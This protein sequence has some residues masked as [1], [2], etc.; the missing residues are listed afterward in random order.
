MRVAFFCNL[1]ILKKIT[2]RFLRDY[3]CH[4]KLQKKGFCSIANVSR[5]QKTYPHIL[6]YLN[7]YPV[8]KNI[9]VYSRLN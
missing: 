8:E 4:S 5:R 9:S 3:R 1:F 7:P 6:L 2:G